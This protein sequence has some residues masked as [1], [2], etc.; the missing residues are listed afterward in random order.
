MSTHV[1]SDADDDS[2]QRQASYSKYPRYVSRQRMNARYGQ[3]DGND[4]LFYG[5]YDRV[6]CMDYA[7]MS[8]SV[9]RDY[10]SI[11]YLAASISTATH[12]QAKTMTHQMC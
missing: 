2:T 10:Y 8:G 1:W 7:S 11:W 5:D 3:D 9:H 6:I 4:E 12:D